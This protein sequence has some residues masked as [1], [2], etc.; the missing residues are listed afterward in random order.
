[1]DF[2]KKK[3]KKNLYAQIKWHGQEHGHGCG[4]GRSLL[5]Q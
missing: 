4:L 1:M 3:K 5:V 2:T